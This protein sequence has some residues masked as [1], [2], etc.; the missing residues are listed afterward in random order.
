MIFCLSQTV[1]RKNYL[2]D[3]KTGIGLYGT[4]ILYDLR[5]RYPQLLLKSRAISF[6]QVPDFSLLSGK[7][8]SKS[9]S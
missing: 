1:I 6:A 7:P 2:R 9:L 5:R 8:L 3:E 4:Y